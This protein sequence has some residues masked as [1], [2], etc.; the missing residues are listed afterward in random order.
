MRI[1]PSPLAATLLA[2]GLLAGAGAQAADKVK[3]GFVSTLT[4]PSAVSSGSS[5]NASS[6]AG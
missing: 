2:A 1:A 5:R 6:T 4:G 3:V